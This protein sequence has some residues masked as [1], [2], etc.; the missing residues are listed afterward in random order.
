M[1]IKRLLKNKGTFHPPLLPPRNHKMLDIVV[2]YFKNQNF[3]YTA[4]T[5][6]KLKID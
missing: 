2:D 6:N 5:K 4:K 3:D 1:T